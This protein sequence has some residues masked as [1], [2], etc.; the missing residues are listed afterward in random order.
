MYNVYTANDVY[1]DYFV[2]IVNIVRNVC[3]VY[4]QSTHG[5]HYTHIHT[6]IY[7]ASIASFTNKNYRPEL[8]PRT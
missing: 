4:I 6:Y 7:I 3:N 8:L 2:Y 1:N 5:F